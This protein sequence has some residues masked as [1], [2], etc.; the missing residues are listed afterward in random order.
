MVFS[1]YIYKNYTCLTF[2][3]NFPEFIYIWAIKWD[4]ASVGEWDS[5]TKPATVRDHPRV[6]VVESANEVEWKYWSFLG[7]LNH[8]YFIPNVY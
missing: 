1:I 3:I 6:S 2:L 8:M 7:F 5:S 4:E